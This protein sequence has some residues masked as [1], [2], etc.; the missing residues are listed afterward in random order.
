M[1][2]KKCSRCGKKFFKQK[3]DS[4]HYWEKK[5]YCSKSCA[6]SGKRKLSPERLENL[7]DKMLGNKLTLGFKH[8]EDTKKKMSISRKGKRRN[9]PFGEKAYNWKGGR[10]ELVKCLQAT[11]RY[12]Q[13]RMDVFSRDKFTCQYCGYDKGGTIEAHHIRQ[14]SLILFENR[15]TTT[16]EAM[17]CKEL[18]D[19]NNG[20]T[21]C[22][23]CHKKTD[24]Y[25]R[26]SFKFLNTE[27]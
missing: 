20:V 5:K 21:L 2:Y 10:T 3:T 19:I 15:I 17:G 16:E 11:Y 22:R 18:W 7:R 1:E 24:N 8:S 14:L 26:K 9:N 13:W 27:F 23:D 6:N 4:K 12:K 25:G